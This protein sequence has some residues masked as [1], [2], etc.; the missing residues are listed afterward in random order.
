MG[1]RGVATAGVAVARRFAS[2]ISYAP[3]RS[4]GKDPGSAYGTDPVCIAS[5]TKTREAPVKYGENLFPRRDQRVLPSAPPA[6]FPRAAVSAPAPEPI[7][8]DPPRVA[9]S[10]PPTAEGPSSRLL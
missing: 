5:E 10:S 7:A 6:S 4:R 2:D 3:S 9:E 8:A 1:L